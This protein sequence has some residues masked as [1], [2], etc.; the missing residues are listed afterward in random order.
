MDMMTTTITTKICGD[1]G[2]YKIKENHNLLLMIK[3]GLVDMITITTI[4]KLGCDA[5]HN[6]YIR[7]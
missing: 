7:S 3:C 6:A 1:D 5:L 4:I 2:K